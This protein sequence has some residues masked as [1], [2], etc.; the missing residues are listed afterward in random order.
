MY[1]RTLNARLRRNQLIAAHP[2]GR[3]C[4]NFSARC[5]RHVWRLFTLDEETPKRG[6]DLLVTTAALIVLS[7][8]Y[9]L[10]AALIKLDDRGPVFFAQ[11]RIGRHG[12][13]FRMLKFRSM[14][15]DAEQRLPELLA[16]NQHAQGIT[17]KIKSDPR[18]T[19]VGRWL[20]RYS[21]D[22]L[23]QLWN[24]FSGEMSLVGPR[25]PLP[26]EVAQYSLA[27]RRRL[28]AKPGITCSWQ[29]SGR[30]NIDFSGQVRL[31]VDYIENQGLA[32]D[33]KILFRTVP[34]VLS[35]T[36]AY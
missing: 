28:A 20:R 33:L 27:D 10:I 30:A 6:L 22:E 7:P 3:H 14:S 23:P 1:A 21:L 12:R 15:C 35:G 16:Q 32:T 25:P 31:D 24:V 9:L 4:L 11:T 18:V 36:G 26:R 5:R 2:W 34:A 13:P 8:V 17:F 29:I 19:R